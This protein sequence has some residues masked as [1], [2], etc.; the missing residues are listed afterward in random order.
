MKTIIF[1][2]LAGLAIA[3]CHADSALTLSTGLDYSSGKYGEATRTETMVVPLG[4]KYEV[5]DWTLRATIPYVESNGPSTVSGS[6]PDRVTI[7]NGSNV[8]RKASG[9]GESP[10]AGDPDI[11]DKINAHCDVLVAGGGPAGLAPTPL[12]VDHGEG[13]RGQVHPRPGQQLN[14]VFASVDELRLEGVNRVFI[15]R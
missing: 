1:P 5:G 14:K 3:P 4:I 2:L 10:R 12:E 8:R 7:D 15:A 6:G 9:L 11:Y 13:G